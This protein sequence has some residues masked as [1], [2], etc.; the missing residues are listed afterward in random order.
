[1]KAQGNALGVDFTKN[2]SPER[3]TQPVSPFQG[4]PA[5]DV[6]CPRALPWAFMLCPFGAETTDFRRL[7]C[8]EEVHFSPSQSLPFGDEPKWKGRTFAEP[9]QFSRGHAAA[10]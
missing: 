8:Y 5:D 4:L 7:K 1:M 2:A 3:A 9:L 6:A 10:S